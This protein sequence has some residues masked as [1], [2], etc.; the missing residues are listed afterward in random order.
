MKRNTECE[1]SFLTSVV[2]QKKTRL[3]VHSQAFAEVL[4]L[5]IF[6]AVLHSQPF[7]Q[8]SEAIR[9]GERSGHT[10]YHSAL[11]GKCFGLF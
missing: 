3:K 1:S 8:R 5:G 9:A 7:L 2:R 10:H 6:M 4:N 11:G